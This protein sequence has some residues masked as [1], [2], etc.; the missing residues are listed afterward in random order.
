M[1]YKPP[2]QTVTDNETTAL[3]SSEAVFEALKGKAD[4]NL[5][6]LSIS[7][8]NGQ[9]LTLSGGVPVWA[10]ASGGGGGGSLPSQSGNSGK[11]LTTNGTT[12]SWGSIT[13]FEP[14]LTKGNLTESTSSVLT[15]TGG[16]GSVIGSGTSIQ[17]KQSSSSVSGF[18]SST[19]WSTFNSKQAALVSGTNIKTVGGTSLLGSGDVS[20]GVT[21]VTGTSPVSSSGGATPAISLESAYGDTQNPYGSKTAN[22]FLAAP[23]GTAGTP[24][25]RAIV[26]ADIPTLNQ[27]T[28]GTAA[29]ITATSNSSLTTL[30]SLSLPGSQVSGNISGN[31]ANVTGTVAVANGGTGQTTA[32]AAFNALAPS[33]STHSGKYL[34]TNGTDT[35]WATIS[36]FEPT[37]TKGNLTE[38]TSGV[39]TITGGTGSVIGSGTSIQVKQASG[40]QSGFLS[41]ADWTTFNNKQ[42]SGS[43]IT[44]LTGD[45]TASGPGSVAATIATVAGSSVSTATANT[46]DATVTTLQTIA[47]SSNSILGIEVKVA[48]RRTGGTAGSANDS[49][50]YVLH[51]MA[52]NNAG[53]V[54]I[55]TVVAD[56]FEDQAGWNA[57]LVVSGTNVLV[58]VTG[59]LNNNISW[60]ASTQTI[61][62]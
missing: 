5:Q 33:Q 58:R 59:A 10:D 42:A 15:I 35:S 34:T 53:T 20:V 30:S 6:N 11:Y 39:L 19:D 38:S 23:N 43:Y 45:V 17:V 1:A 12:A 22:Q 46:T 27:N 37:L 13:G 31:S 50:Y 3:P 49:A 36:G 61:S 9:V 44:A 4:V 32:N 16:T 28:T 26:A 14:T 2:S 54:T 62:V 47:T 52:K 56:E 7:G 41:S 24:S 8:T 57:D 55:S 21:S 51:G 29:N 48:A 25:F 18:L 60:K 40:S